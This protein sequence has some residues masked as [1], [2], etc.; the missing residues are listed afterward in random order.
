MT[1][2]RTRSRSRRCLHLHL[3]GTPPTQPTTPLE[4]AEGRWTLTVTGLDDQGLGS[5]ATRRF[6]VNST[7]ASLRVAP[8][9][10]VVRPTGGRVDIRWT[11]ARAA[12]V[13]VT[14][15]TAEGIV[16][17]TVSNTPVQAGEQ[18]VIWDGRAGNRK[19]VGTGRYV[20]RV[21][22][23]ERAGRR[24]ADAARDRAPRRALRF[25]TC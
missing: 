18:A 12:R 20:A 10:V 4:P 23:H 8:G 25:G 16:V 15:E 1:P 22:A 14:I 6:W 21:A 11:Q 19:P 2:A 17:R 13:K 7:L 9:R 3:P 5:T 24:L